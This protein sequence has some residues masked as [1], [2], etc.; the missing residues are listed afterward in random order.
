MPEPILASTPAPTP[1][2]VARAI[3]VNTPPTQPAPQPEDRT[4]RESQYQIAVLTPTVR[5]AIDYLNTIAAND[6]ELSDNL[7]AYRRSECY[8]RWLGDAL[9]SLAALSNPSLDPLLTATR[10]EIVT[11]LERR[12]ALKKQRMALLSTRHDARQKLDREIQTTRRD[13]LAQ[14]AGN[15][16]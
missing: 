15:P 8:I 7:A 16:I 14:L 6:I 5:E 10:E 2:P 1:I 3:P 13:R 4:P 11:L 12:D 9:R